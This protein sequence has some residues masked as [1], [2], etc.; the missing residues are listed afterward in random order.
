MIVP[1][2]MFFFYL[3]S[4][5]FGALGTGTEAEGGEGWIIVFFFWFHQKNAQIFMK[6]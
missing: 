1:L 4:G 2:L 5:L 3:N 6:Q